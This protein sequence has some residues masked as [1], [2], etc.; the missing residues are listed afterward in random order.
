MSVAYLITKKE[1]AVLR[2]MVKREKWEGTPEDLSRVLKQ[3]TR[4]GY[5]F[6]KNQS[7]T[8]ERVI[9][10]LIE[11]MEK[12]PEE[13]VLSDGE[14]KLYKNPGL[15]I[16]LEKDPHSKTQYKLKPFPGKN[17]F[18]VSEEGQKFSGACS[19]E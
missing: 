19:D 2:A 13:A 1:V 4:R 3:L 12:T 16:F 15:W 18:E 8:V 5:V 14:N 10:G 7:Y 6:Q 11:A 9:Y 17:A